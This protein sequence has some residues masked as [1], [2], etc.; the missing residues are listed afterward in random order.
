MSHRSIYLVRPPVVE[1]TELE[2]LESYE[3]VYHYLEV[4]SELWRLVGN[5]ERARAIEQSV[6]RA[7]DHHTPT[8]ETADIAKLLEQLEGLDVAVV[9]PLTDEHHMIAADKLP[10][11][12]TRSELLDLD[13]ARGF[14][15]RAAISEAIIGVENLQGALRS[16]LELGAHIVID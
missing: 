7:H 9:G 14:D 8:L 2:V 12:R 15:A 6:A 5:Q 11:L 13:E 1:D 4:A 10:E 16:A 3:R